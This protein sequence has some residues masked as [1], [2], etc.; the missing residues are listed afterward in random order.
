MKKRFVALLVLLI[1]MCWTAGALAVTIPATRDEVPVFDEVYEAIERLPKISVQKNSDGSSTIIFSSNPFF[2]DEYSEWGED[3]CSVSFSTADYSYYELT[4]S[5][6]VYTGTGYTYTVFNVDISFVNV[7]VQ[8]NCVIDEYGNGGYT[9]SYSSFYSNYDNEES[10]SYHYNLW[11]DEYTKNGGLSYDL[12]QDGKVTYFS[13]HVEG[14]NVDYDENGNVDT[15]SC[16]DGIYY[17][18]FN[19]YGDPIR[20]S[21]YLFISA[22]DGY[23]ERDYYWTPE[24]GWSYTEQRPG[25]Y[26]PT[27]CGTPDGI[28]DPTDIE[29]PLA[30]P[31]VVEVYPARLNGSFVVGSPITATMNAENALAYNYWLFN[32]QGVIVQE[33]TNTTDTTWTFTVSEPGI[34]LLRTYATDFETEDWADTDWFAVEAVSV[35]PVTVSSVTVSGDLKAGATLTSTAVVENGLAFN[36][37]LFND[38]GAIVQEYTNTTDTAWSF[39]VSEPGLYLLRVYATDFITENW[40]D[41]EWFYVTKAASANPVVISS[42]RLSE[43]NI[44]QGDTMTVTPTVSGGSGLY[45]YN[46]WVFNTA[47]AIVMEKTN[48]LDASASF[49]F[50]EPG[51]YLIRVYATDFES[52]HDA[53]SEWFAVIAAVPAQQDEELVA[54]EETETE[55]PAEALP[56]AEQPVDGPQLPEEVPADHEPEQEPDLAA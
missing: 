7:S 54:E 48:T 50:T 43:A 1:A 8:A 42:V 11:H 22:D 27:P 21:Y 36:Y 6:I 19:K 26:E 9:T 39:S 16:T 49:T 17:V 35:P 18:S 34:Y 10:L 4:K 51:V 47:G 52:E 30:L 12:D 55:Q 28:V 5:D 31:R 14:Y 2:F 40:N 53:D 44:H 56:E 13:N 23:F 15:Y 38:Q 45:A 41:S 3:Y 25:G 24:D 37:W 29:P 33:Y 46:Y 32:D 20:A